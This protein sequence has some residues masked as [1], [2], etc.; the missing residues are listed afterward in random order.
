MSDPSLPLQGEIVRKLKN[1][2]T[3]K[4][5][6]QNKIYDDVPRDNQG[7][8]T[9][10]LPYVSLGEDQVLPDKADCLDGREVI[11]TIHAWDKGPGYPQ[12]K[13]IS[14]AIIAA[15]DDVEFTVTG[16]RVIEFGLQDARH[17]PEPDGITRHAVIVFRA[18][19]EPVS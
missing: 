2:A 14:S 9:A 6:V 5:L 10:Q 15:L 4:S 19:T 8:I 16:H 3:L 1:D 13:R 12:V 18:L 17:L 11:L 7:N